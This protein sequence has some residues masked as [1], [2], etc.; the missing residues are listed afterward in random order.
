MAVFR[1]RHLLQRPHLSRG[2]KNR[3]ARRCE[4]VP[5]RRQIRPH[6]A[7]PASGA[8]DGD[9]ERDRFD[10]AQESRWRA[11]RSGVEPM[12]RSSRARFLLLCALAVVPRLA[13]VLFY[14]L[15]APPSSWGDDWHYD[16][17]ARQLLSERVYTDGWFPPGYPLLLTGIYALFGAHLAVVRLVQVCFG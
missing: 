6:G 5:L 11:G 9:A 13:F 10:A 4:R 14:G 15:N 2:E 12:T 7:A 3:L 8:G 16:R 17:I 1:S